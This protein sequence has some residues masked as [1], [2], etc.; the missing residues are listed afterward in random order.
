MKKL[1]LF[2]ISLVAALFSQNATAQ[3]LVRTASPAES[4]RVEVTSSSYAAATSA[5]AFSKREEARLKV[6]AE[7]AKIGAKLGPVPGMKIAEALYD[8]EI[9]ANDLRPGES[10]RFSYRVPAGKDEHS[11]ELFYNI[12]V[13][14]EARP[15]GGILQATV[16]LVR[17]FAGIGM[18]TRPIAHESMT[19]S[20]D[21][22]TPEVAQAFVA[23]L[24]RN[25]T[26][27]LE[28]FT[29]AQ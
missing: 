7:T 26:Q 13:S 12:R 19:N 16:E 9:A 4:Q 5:A 1:L 10:R 25:L 21:E 23:E 8:L 2:A 15:V 24:Q 29:A 20:V 6:A 14:F 18:P 27:K 11:K 28:G 22:F 17:G 3:S